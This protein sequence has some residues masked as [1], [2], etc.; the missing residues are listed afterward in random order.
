MTV[1]AYPAPKLLEGGLDLIFPPMCVGCRHVGRWICPECWPRVPWIE[2][3]QCFECAKPS[4]TVRC[5][6]CSGMSRSLDRLVAVAPAPMRKSPATER[7]VMLIIA[8]VLKSQVMNPRV[9]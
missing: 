5:V 7:P 9:Q 4:P 2:D 3:R 1:P 6:R 8:F